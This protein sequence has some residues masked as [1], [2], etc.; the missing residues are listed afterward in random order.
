VGDFKTPI[1][2]KNLFC[3][4]P[5]QAAAIGLRALM[6]GISQDG[7]CAAWMSKLAYDLW[8]IQ[9]GTWYG[10]C[11]ITERRADLLRQLAEESGGWWI[12]N[13]ESEDDD[14]SFV[15]LAEFEALYELRQ[16]KQP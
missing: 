12:W 2:I 15:T 11:L 4:S 8:K 13:D 9:A 16:A 7:W 1:D 14:L 3:D 10:R 5:E 6:T